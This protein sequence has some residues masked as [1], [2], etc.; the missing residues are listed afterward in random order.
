MARNWTNVAEDSIQAL[1]SC[2][3][4]GRVVNAE[5]SGIRSPEGTSYC[6][7]NCYW[8][9]QLDV[10]NARIRRAR[11][12]ARAAAAAAAGRPVARRPAQLRRTRTRDA[13]QAHVAAAD[14]HDNVDVSKNTNCPYT[15]SER[16]REEKDQRRALQAE[17]DATNTKSGAGHYGV[18]GDSCL[19]CMQSFPPINP[20]S[21]LADSA[22][23]PT[24][25]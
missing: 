23:C 6:G 15:A 2:H 25:V 18:G 9:E 7:I 24:G 3:N 19:A 22:F 5:F 1:V 17:P 11:K 4:C 13:E 14:F 10:G 8:S 20:A 21:T 16:R 12:K